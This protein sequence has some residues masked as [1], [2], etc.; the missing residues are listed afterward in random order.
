[1]AEELAGVGP[2][3]GLGL[4][5]RGQVG[6]DPAPASSASAPRSMIASRYAPEDGAST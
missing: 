6:A 4:E 2:P 3:A 1:M 5:R